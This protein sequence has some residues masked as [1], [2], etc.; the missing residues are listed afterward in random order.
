MMAK[1]RGRPPKPAAEKKSAHAGLRL[2]APL[3][4]RLAAAA[5]AGNRTISQ[6]IEARLRLSFGQHQETIDQFGG[7]TNYWLLRIAAHE[8][9]TVEW[10]AHP[11]VRRRHPDLRRIAD[12]MGVEV[13]AQ[14]DDLD[15]APKWWDDPYTFKQVKILINTFLDFFKPAGRA[16]TPQ[17]HAEIDEPLGQRSAEKEMA[18]IEFA[19]MA[20]APLDGYPPNTP[21][22]P[23]GTLTGPNPW[24][25]AREWFAA[26]GPLVPKLTKSPLAKLYGIERRKK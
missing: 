10:L 15:D 6:E 4:E 1:S 26:A 22:L 3:Y 16:V 12:E 13:P 14:P 18:N 19:L 11:D 23:P 5:R 7:P 21:G 8:I 20:G 9:G 24:P 2:A 17:I 25:R